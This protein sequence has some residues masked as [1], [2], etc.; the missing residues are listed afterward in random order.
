MSSVQIR[1]SAQFVVT[2]VFKTVMARALVVVDVQN[3]FCSGGALE[4]PG[5]EKI[6]PNVNRLAENFENVVL[7]QDW[8]PEGHSSFASSHEGKDPFQTV[9]M[10]YGEQV[11]WPDHCIQGSYG[12][13]LHQD[14]DRTQADVIVRKG[15]N[16]NIDSYSAFVENDGETLTGLRGYLNERDINTLYI[17]GLAT[18]FCVKWTALDA[19]PTFDTVV[20]E[21]ATKGLEGE[22]EALANFPEQGID[23]ETTEDVLA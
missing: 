4:V 3:D 11:L 22:D 18:D 1:V 7:T 5:G 14:L 19:V 13:A 9:D 6:I 15:Y 10:D 12:A 23:V 20:V 16:R 8:H 2:T 17:C 21:D